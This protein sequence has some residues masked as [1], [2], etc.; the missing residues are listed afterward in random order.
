MKYEVI[1]STGTRGLTMELFL[2]ALCSV[3]FYSWKGLVLLGDGHP[4]C[5]GC[6]YSRSRDAQQHS[7]TVT[8]NFTST[9]VLCF[10]RAGVPKKLPLGPVK[11]SFKLG[12]FQTINISFVSNQKLTFYLLMNV[13][14]YIYIYIFRM[15]Q[16]DTRDRNQSD[17]GHNFRVAY[18]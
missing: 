7:V 2:R 15:A 5:G 17:I 9:S 8:F 13:Y 4:Y 3:G 6:F 12:F 16:F 11:R 1:F 10:L 14:V 18:R